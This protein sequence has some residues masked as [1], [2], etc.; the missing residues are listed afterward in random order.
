MLSWGGSGVGDGGENP[1]AT[2]PCGEAGCAAVRVSPAADEALEVVE[3]RVLCDSWAR[4]GGEC[5]VEGGGDVD[6][7]REGRG[8]PWPRPREGPRSSPSSSSSDGWAKGLRA[9]DRRP[10]SPLRRRQCGRGGRRGCA[11]SCARRLDQDPLRLDLA[12]DPADVAAQAVGE[13]EL[14]VAVAQEWMSSPRPRPRRPPARRGGSGDVGRGDGRVEATGIAVGD[15][16]VHGQPAS[17]QGDTVPVA[18][19]SKSSGWAVTTRTGS[20]RLRRAQRV[21]LAADASGSW[22]PGA[23]GTVV[24]PSRAWQDRLHVR[25]VCTKVTA[26]A[27]WTFLEPRRLLPR[28]RRALVALACARG[29]AAMP[30]TA[31]VLES[32]ATAPLR[33]SHRAPCGPLPHAVFGPPM[34]LDVEYQGQELCSTKAKAGATKLAALIRCDLRPR[35][36][37]DPPLLLTAARAS[38]RRAVHSTGWSASGRPR[39][40]AGRR[41]RRLAVGER[42]LMATRRDRPAHRYHVH[43]LGQQDLA[44]VRHKPG[45]DRPQGLHRRPGAKGRV[46]NLLPPHHVAISLTWEGAAG[47]SRSGRGR[48]CHRR[49]PRAGA[50][51]AGAPGRRRQTLVPIT[52][53][54][55][56]ADQ[57]RQGGARPER[58]SRLARRPRDL[59]MPVLGGAWTADGRGGRH[60]PGR[61]E[62]AEHANCTCQYHADIAT[63][64]V[65]TALTAHEYSSTR[66][67]RSP[68]T[69]RSRLER[70]C[71]PSSRSRLRLGDRRGAGGPPAA[72]ATVRPT[73]TWWRR[74]LA[75]RP[76]RRA[77]KPGETGAVTLGRQADPKAGVGGLSAACTTPGRAAPPRG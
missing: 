17:V 32:S 3:V 41:V 39:R 24:R 76:H 38:T 52:A 64:A 23:S 2:W 62:R 31:T 51:T 8:G 44:R 25:V 57:R 46:R 70:G 7:V 6:V 60:G 53:V 50:P 20:R 1:S 15:D 48:S 4:R 73:R 19:K 74:T 9:S 56:V 67:S 35:L 49:A 63:V 26:T 11:P 36:H 58:R 13:G 21:R 5:A 42:R 37:R 61:R 33:P 40:R 28:A 47:L 77:L 10:G 22:C 55:S 69:A 75:V 72:A 18:P 71:P 16:A 59:V 43:R 66:S 29:R 14:S 45:M 34:D 54:R 65:V 12:D 27:R 30:V 68:P